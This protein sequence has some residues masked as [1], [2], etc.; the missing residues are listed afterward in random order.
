MKMYLMRTMCVVASAI[1]MVVLSACSTAPS[2]VQGKTD[3]RKDAATA[4][5]KAQVSD[6]SLTGVLRSAAGY[7]VFPSIG[8]GGAVVGGAY[9]KGVL[10]VNGSQVGFCDLSQASIGAQLGA[11]V[12]TEIV[13]FEDS[14]SVDHFRQGK[15]NFD[16]QASAVALK[17]GA[18]A[19]AKYKNGVA[20]FTMDEAGLMAEASIGGQRFTYQ[21]N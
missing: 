7:A 14:K 8:K 12:Y 17:S 16:A 15:L 10:Y 20:V 21:A 1:T 9:G 2:S 4:F 5:S 19:N 13:C 11:Q 6:P 18:G 3:I